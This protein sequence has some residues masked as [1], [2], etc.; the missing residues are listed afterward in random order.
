MG[1]VA[2]RYAHV[3]DVH[4]LA[5]LAPSSKEEGRGKRDYD[6]LCLAGSKHIQDNFVETTIL[7][8][9]VLST[10]TAKR[11]KSQVCTHVIFC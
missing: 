5:C 1:T 8:I 9:M 3:H 2:Y 6:V 11:N 7:S 10:E 4:S